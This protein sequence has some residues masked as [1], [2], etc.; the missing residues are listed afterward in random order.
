MDDEGGQEEFGDD[1]DS[2][3]HMMFIQYQLNIRIHPR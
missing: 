2:G 3:M 1:V